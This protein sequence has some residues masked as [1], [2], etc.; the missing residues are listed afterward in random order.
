MAIN[1]DTNLQSNLHVVLGNGT[2]GNRLVQ[3]L[4]KN[5]KQVIVITQS[6]VA[7]P[8]AGVSYIVANA[9][10]AK[11]LLNAVPNAKV[12]YNCVNPPYQKWK[13]QWPEISKAVNE[14][15]IKTNANLVTSSNLYGYGSFDG[16][17]TEDTP[18]RATWTNGKVRA[19]MWQ[20]VKDLFDQGK[21]K[22]TEVRGS[23]YICANEQSRMGHRVVPNLI[24]GKP[25]RLLGA[26]DQPH[27]WTDPDDVAQLMMVLSEDDRSWGRPWHVPSNEPKTQR[28]VVKDIA[29]HLRISNYQ[30]SAIGAPI[31]R[32]LGFFNPLIREL[33]K[34]S[35]QFNKPF[36]MSS[37]VTCETFGLVPKS[38][39]QVIEDLT[40]PYLEY[41]EKN[42]LD[43]ISKLGNKRI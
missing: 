17:L 39:N 40:R 37:K 21:L 29:S 14:F 32:I 6:K 23:D 41:V 43:S 1:S 11:S 10:S 33:N 31:E 15:A 24:L 35:Y 18:Q 36:V 5:K 19:E 16:V 22:A 13:T 9:N 20:E 34:G 30:L 2:V 38:W 42:G 27:T 26:L 8:V 3:L 7:T 12:I 25:V 28:E 4:A